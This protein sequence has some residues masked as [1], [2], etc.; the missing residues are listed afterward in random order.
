MSRLVYGIAVIAIFTWATW[1]RFALPLDPIADQDTWGYLYPAVHRLTGGEFVHAGGRNFLYPAFLFLL[2]RLFGDL[3]A[4]VVAQHFL[5]LASGALFLL[6]WL[7]ARSLARP[8]S[9][10]GTIHCALGLIALAIILGAGEPIRAEMQI[11]PEG[12][13]AFVVS[14][15]LWLAMEFARRAFIERDSAVVACGIGTIGTAVALESLKPSFGLLALVSVLPVGIFFLRRHSLPQKLALALGGAAAAALLLL[16]ERFLSREDEFGQSFLPTTL[17]VFHA[18]LIR[19]QI[20]DDIRQRAPVP[21]A[22]DWLQRMHDQ[23]AGEIEKSAAGE[24]GHF[25]SIGFFPDYLM[26]DSSS[27]A[28]QIAREFG[29][30]VG[31]TNA[32]FLFYYWRT[33]WQRPVEMLGRIGSQMAFFYQR[34]CPVFDREKAVR[35]TPSYQLGIAGLGN[36]LQTELSYPPMAEFA[37]QTAV[38]AERAPA[39]EQ[40]KFVRRGVAFLAGAYL[41]LLVLTIGLAIAVCF[42]REERRRIGWLVLLTLFVFSYNFTACLETAVVISLEFPRYVMVQFYFT[43]LAEFLALWLILEMLVPRLRWTRPV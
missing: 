4:I 1:R 15:N 12:V 36:F 28:A 24:K 16:P 30:D 23:L 18:D 14:L 38:W 3:R 37:R 27:S 11:R 17:F 6:T 43:V 25:L 29:D 31:R 5:G 21:Y 10:I 7:R 40:N 39:I 2:L 35:L 13:C 8:S 32:F 41:P 9:Q 34:I 20:A 19:D 26:Y 22:H 33:W 42:Y